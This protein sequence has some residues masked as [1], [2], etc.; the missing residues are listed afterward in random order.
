M[1]IKVITYNIHSGQDAQNIYSLE[2]VIAVLRDVSAD[3]ICL[4]EVDK[5]WG[6]RS[7]FED[8]PEIISKALGME[9]VYSPSLDE[10]NKDNP[11]RR[12]QYGE[13]LLCRYPIKEKTLYKMYIKDDSAISYDGTNKTESRS[14]I[15]AKLDVESK[16]LWVINTHLDFAQQEE[17]TRQ[18]KKLEKIIKETSGALILCGDLNAG[19][20]TEEL[21]IL[22]KYLK[23]SASGK[24]FISGPAINPG[25]IDHILI[26]GVFVINVSMINAYASDHRPVV[27]E[28][29]V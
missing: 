11:K 6:E 1:K 17:R 22:T 18:V 12:R 26:R 25:R 28:L 14:A 27:A 13:L 29:E 2:A 8:Q 20:D 24:N 3:I 5:N 9:S 4:Q 19:P 10:E 23:D 7:N 21:M 16:E 15:L